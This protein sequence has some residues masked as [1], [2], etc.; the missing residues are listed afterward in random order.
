MDLE[1]TGINPWQNNILDFPEARYTKY[2]QTAEKF[3][4]IQLG[5]CTWHKYFNETENK[6][7]FIARPYTIYVFP[8]ENV[9]NALLNCETS[10]IIF[11]REHGMDFNKWIYKGKIFHLNGNKQFR[12]SIYECKTGK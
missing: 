3:R 2:K 5:I 11:N 9:G 12:G 1:L 6:Y 4:I 8:E 7:K 10:A